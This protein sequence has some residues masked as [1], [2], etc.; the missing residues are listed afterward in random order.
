MASAVRD[1]EAGGWGRGGGVRVIVGEL[2]SRQLVAERLLDNVDDDGGRQA[3]LHL[4]HE[5]LALAAAG[6]RARGSAWGSVRK[7]ARHESI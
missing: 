1:C 2:C 3:L 5:V 7:V 4:F 6:Q